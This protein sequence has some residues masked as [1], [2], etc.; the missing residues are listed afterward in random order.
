LQ[1]LYE[2]PKWANDLDGVLGV[3]APLH[4]SLRYGEN[5]DEVRLANPKRWGGLGAAVGRAVSAILF[6]LGRGPLLVY[7]GQEVGEPALGAEGFGG[8]DGR[9]S[10]FDYGSMP[11]LAKWVNGHRYDGGRLPSE[12]R[13]LRAWYA[14]LLKLTD[15]PAF[16]HG[17][18]LPLNRANGSN[19]RFGRL[20]GETASGHWLYAFLR[21]DPRSRQRFLVVANLHG[22]QAL[23][24]VR[25]TFPQEAIQ[26]LGAATGDAALE[27][28][29][30]LATLA[31]LGV[32]TTASVL[33]ERGLDM[34]L[35]PPLTAC[36]FEL[37]P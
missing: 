12:Q 11:E 8:D 25:I 17:E 22:R 28:H 31:P 9:T 26:A 15:A 27:F 24:D 36:Y 4:Q 1:G 21:H 29:D 23:R 20:P 6:G 7:N 33:R 37:Q 30:R 35:L 2:G 19:P 3:V 14:H 32:Q 16:R 10:I 5:H 13:D 34:P 18:F